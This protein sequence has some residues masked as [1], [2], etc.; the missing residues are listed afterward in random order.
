MLANK[1]KRVKER[2]NMENMEEG[3]ELFEEHYL[4][5]K[6]YR[7][8]IYQERNRRDDGLACVVVDNGS[9]FLNGDVK[10]RLS[11]GEWFYLIAHQ[12]LHIAFGH[13]DAEK[14]TGKNQSLEE[15]GIRFEEKIWNLACD[16]YNMKFL[17]DMKIG[18]CPF[19]EDGF[20]IGTMNER[21]IYEYLLGN[22]WTEAQKLQAAQIAKLISMEGLKVPNVYENGNPHVEGFARALAAAVRGVL[23]NVGEENTVSGCSEMTKQ[24]KEWFISHYPLLGGMAAG[25]TIVENY[26]LCVREEIQIAAVGIDEGVIYLNPAAHLTMEELKFVLAHEFLHAG[27][28]HHERCMGRDT[29]LW[30]VACDF[31]INEWLVELGVGCMPAD[32]LYDKELKDLSAESIYDKIVQDIRKARRLRTLRGYGKGDVLRGNSRGQGFGVGTG[33]MAGRSLEDFY[34]DAISQ[35]LEFHQRVGRGYL[36]AGLVEEIRALGMPAISWDVEL[37]Q[38]FEE[39]F[40]LAEKYRSYARPS[41]RQ[42]SSPDIPRPRMTERDKHGKSRTF[43]VV[44]DTSGSMSAKMLG[45]ALGSI[46]SFAAAKEVPFVRVEVKGR[47]GTRLQP[48][49]DCLINAKDFPK[50]GPILIITDGDIESDLRVKR[51]HAF[52]IPQGKQLPFRNWGKVFYLK[53]NI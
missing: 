10:N 13:F 25:F 35:G 21:E 11:P 53:E 37:A 32:V 5:G 26:E 45:M 40:P 38:W 9:I 36:P 48:G 46:A 7:V 33:G 19:P 22:E 20:E 51:E 27:L 15:S 49:V 44:I 28:L 17:K 1:G 8:N 39:H 16:L 30:N 24:A 31:V 2:R 50:E 18:R 29:Y 41:R 23:Q 14:I 3:L 4:F 47:G 42:S 6:V 34:K 52:L 43:G 12:Y